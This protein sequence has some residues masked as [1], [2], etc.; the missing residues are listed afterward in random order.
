MKH[1]TAS[2]K[3]KEEYCCQVVRINKLEPIE[4]SDFLAK[5]VVAGNTMVVRKDEFHEGDYAIYAKNE[6][7]LNGAFLSSNNLFELGEYEKNANADR[8]ASLIAEGKKDEARA[9]VGFFNKYGRVKA[10]KLRGVYSMGLLFG[11]DSLAKWKTDVSNEDLRQYIVN[12][13]MGIGENFDTVCGEVFVKAYVPRVTAHTPYTRTRSASQTNTSRF[14]KISD[15]DWHF[16]YDTLKANDNIWKIVPDDIVSI[17]VKEHGTSGIFGNVKIKYPAHLTPVQKLANYLAKIT[18]KL[19][20][21]CDARTVPTWYEGYG[22]IY[23]SRNVIKNKYADVKDGHNFHGAD[24]WGEYNDLL[25]PY[26]DRGMMVY[27]EICGYLTDD[28]KMIQKSYDYGCETGHNFLMPYRITTTDENGETREWNI[29]EVVD[30][31]KQLIS[32]HPKLTERIKPLTVLYHGT[33]ADL[34]P[35]INTDENWHE[36]VLDAMKN[37]AARLGLEKREPLCKN[38]VPREGICIRVDNRPDIRAMKLTSDAFYAKEQKLI[39]AGE[40]DMEMVGAYYGD[41]N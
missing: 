7:E 23:S 12:E 26:I 20:K 10:L 11:L 35:N 34:Y 6:T 19:Y 1:F 8:I 4:G 38:K 16:H 32:D 36:L 39:D 30:W 14:E 27:G 28:S 31:T 40:V 18:L 13:E 41:Q 22:N 3:M 25:S 9:L 15:A 37:D 17:S 2:D 24:I 21:W 5:T 29:S 33:L